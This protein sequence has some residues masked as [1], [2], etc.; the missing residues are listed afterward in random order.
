MG[1][2][3]AVRSCFS[4]SF[5]WKGRAPRSEYWWFVLF[6]CVG[7]PTALVL[8]NLLGINFPMQTVTMD[9]AVIGT[10]TYGTPGYIYF[11]F[12]LIYAL[13]YSSVLVRRFHDKNK[14]GWWCWI[15]LVPLVGFI[16]VLVWLC[17]RGTVGKNDYGP[18]PLG[19]A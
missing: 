12:L 2:T 17:Q 10:S 11:L 9:G 14:S 8:D 1:F 3:Q 5:S 18:D 16:L 6:L 4:K 7:A 13:P 15:S 19:G